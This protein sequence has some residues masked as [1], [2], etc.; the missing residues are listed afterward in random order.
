MHG[1]V[2]SQ[3]GN[4]LSPAC[5]SLPFSMVELLKSERSVAEIPFLKVEGGS[6]G[7]E[8]VLFAVHS[9]L[10]MVVTDSNPGQKS[11]MD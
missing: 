10:A 4:V 1:N 6:M 3:N 7:P 9:N 11:V 8:C 2:L 5:T